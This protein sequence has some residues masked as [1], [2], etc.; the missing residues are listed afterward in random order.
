MKL[1]RKIIC[2]KDVIMRPLPDE[3]V[4]AKKFTKGNKYS[5]N[6][7]GR[8]MESL[9]DYLEVHSLGQTEG[10]DWFKEH[11][12]IIDIEETE[13]MVTI[14]KAE[15][16][17]LKEEAEKLSKLEAWGVDNWSGYGEALAQEYD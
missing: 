9:N 13:E 17:S 4:G 3:T 15:Y 16:E 7:R 1:Q 10:N 6:Y 2:I 11:F 12:E 14:T 8:Y 5:L